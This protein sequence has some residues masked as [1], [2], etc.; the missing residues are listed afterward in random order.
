MMVV[1]FTDVVSKETFS[2]A[3]SFLATDSSGR[4]IHPV[5]IKFAENPDYMKLQRKLVEPEEN[6][7][8]KDHSDELMPFVALI[9]NNSVD[10]Y[11]IVTIEFTE[12]NNE[13]CEN[14]VINVTQVGSLDENE[15]K[16][17]DK[18]NAK[19]SSD[20]QF[21]ALCR[22]VADELEEVEPGQVEEIDEVVLM[23]MLMGGFIPD[24]SEEPSE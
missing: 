7:D 4:Q 23:M 13:L 22:L 10:T 11:D 6:D 15:N 24:I 21:T 9:F 19:F 1:T 8:D 18:Y 2:E 14:A 20:P 3:N 16:L 12:E 5:D 17:Y